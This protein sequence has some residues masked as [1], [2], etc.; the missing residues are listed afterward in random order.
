MRFLEVLIGNPELGGRH[1]IGITEAL[2]TTL[3]RGQS[4]E[5][6]NALQRLGGHKKQHTKE[7]RTHCAQH[8]HQLAQLFLRNTSHI[9]HK[10]DYAEEQHSGGEILWR[11]ERT[12][13]TR[14]PQYPLHRIGASTL[15]RLGARKQKG[16]THN[17]TYLGKFGRLD[18]DESE[19]NPTGSIVNIRA[20]EHY[21]QQHAYRCRH[22]RKR[23]SLVEAV[24]HEMKAID[25]NEA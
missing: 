5:S 9:H 7:Q 8:Q 1:G 23:Y 14:H 17:H 22:Q 24:G 10:E 4:V 18:S 13:N 11:N 6:G 2:Y 19:I 16:R 3:P 21:P 20:L 15:I 12:D 25:N